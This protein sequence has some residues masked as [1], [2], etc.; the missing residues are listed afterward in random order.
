MPRTPDSQL[1]DGAGV[2]EAGAVLAGKYQL[3]E[4]L[5]AGGMGKVFKGE[6]LLLHVPIAI[7]VLHPF[8]TRDPNH[9]RRFQ[10]EARAAVLLNHPN[11]V[12]VV[13]FGRHEGMVY[14]VMEFLQGPTLDD[15][16][17]G[18]GTLPPLQEV[19]RIMLQL[20][21]AL[22]AAHARNI[23]HRDLK[24]TNVLLTSGTGGVE[25]K[26]VDF[27]LA[28]VDD[29]A[30]KGPTLT[31]IDAIAGTPAYMSPE[32]CR[33]LA[34]GP[35]T[36]LY[37]LGC[38]LTTL[39][40]GTPPFAARTPMDV[41]AKQ[42]FVPP[43]P[44][45]R[46]SEAEPVPPL[47]ERLRLELLAKQPHQRPQDAATAAARLREALSPEAHARRL[48]TRKGDTPLGNREERS[49]S[50]SNRPPSATANTVALHPEKPLA[51]IDVGVMALGGDA[52]GWNS[53]HAA[54]LAAQGIA[55]CAVAI[56]PDWSQ[57]QQDIVVVDAGNDVARAVRVLR[58]PGTRSVIVCVARPSAGE[59]NQLIE[60]GAAEVLRYPVSPD[61]LAKRIRRAAKRRG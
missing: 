7:K 46:P 52:E 58:E 24:P 45:A 41:I 44:L 13:D 26:I 50:W 2:L 43:P 32:Q 21:S 12:R 4:P 40:Q 37:A 25:S 51:D 60:A 47:L 54:G 42:M 59:M 15:W 33:S 28:H 36:D 1:P 53:T 5:G 29:P 56:S 14:L 55:V 31:Q 23:V 35:S 9:E 30:D 49:P 8:L 19:G 18:L 6:H 22:E 61:T 11:I 34:V 10:R 57:V 20:L 38:L 3:V 48:P 39:L 16:L 17:L 27:G